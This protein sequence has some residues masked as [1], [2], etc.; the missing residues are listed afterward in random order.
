MGIF[1]SRWTWLCLAVVLAG[2]GR[3]DSNLPKLMPVGGVVTLDG[4]PLSCATVTFVPTGSTRVTGAH[5]YTDKEGKYDLTATHGGKGTP[6]GEYRVTTEKW[7]TPDGS[8]FP[9]AVV[10]ISLPGARQILPPKYSD[11]LQTVLRATV[12]SGDNT[13][14]FAIASKP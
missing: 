9:V 13:I 5:G 11:R 4:K 6:V 7:V 10:P 8:D 2:C 1:R 14:D 3:T 12:R